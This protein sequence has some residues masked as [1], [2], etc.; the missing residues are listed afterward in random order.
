M[1]KA[2]QG[3][4]FHSLYHHIDS[5]QLVN[6]KLFNVV[7]SLYHIMLLIARDINISHTIFSHSQLFSSMSKGYEILNIHRV[8]CTKLLLISGLDKNR[9]TQCIQH[10]RRPIK[11]AD[12]LLSMK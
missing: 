9:E 7:S 12:T 3:S 5:D 10:F 6:L 1:G 2:L 11:V 8:H 4:F